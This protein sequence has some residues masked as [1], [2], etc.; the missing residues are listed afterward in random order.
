MQS[1]LADHCGLAS[2]SRDR[3][4]ITRLVAGAVAIGLLP[5]GAVSAKEVLASATTSTVYEATIDGP[6]EATSGLVTSTPSTFTGPDVATLVG[7]DRFYSAGYDGTGAVVSNNE[8][9]HVWSSHET[10]GH[11]STFVHDP[12]VPSAPFASPAIDRHAT[13]VAHALGGRG[14]SDWQ[15]GIAPGAELRSGAIGTTWSGNA[16]ALGFS[17][18]ATSVDAAFNTGS[19]GFGSVDV[20][21]SSWSYVDSAGSNGFTILFDGLAFANPQT[22]QVFAAGNSGSDVNGA[23]SGYN[24]ISVG[25]LENDGSNNYDTVAAFSSRS[26]ND[27]FDPG[28]GTITDV[29]AAVDIVAPG[30]DLTLAFYGGQTG[31]NDASLAGSPTSAAQI[32][33]PAVRAAPAS[34]RRLWPAWPR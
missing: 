1:A 13:W 27:Y 20:I 25:A 29:R 15:T 34:P 7:A 5:V 12:T 22:T 16:Y 19:T 6:I 33:T 2:L 14:A 24:A 28:N 17:F 21:N 23:A 4:L 32:S 8:A 3:S 11:V 30:T 10:L 18:N 26:P 9:G 31:G